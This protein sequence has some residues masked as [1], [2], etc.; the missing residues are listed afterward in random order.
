M[1]LAKQ[2]GKNGWAVYH[3]DPLRSRAESARVNWN[4][5]INR[6]LQD[7]R[8]VLHFQAVHRAADLRVTYFEAL[9]RMVDELSL[10]HI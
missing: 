4:A 3:N 9:V 1:Y 5:R 6:A 8:F 7:Q 2:S 10:I